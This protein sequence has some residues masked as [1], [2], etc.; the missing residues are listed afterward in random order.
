VANWRM[1]ANGI[2]QGCDGV[3][4]PERAAAIRP[5]ATVQASRNASWLDDGDPLHE[6][7]CV[8]ILCT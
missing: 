4:S 3:I 1:S 6:E 5:L 2:S 8:H 7:I